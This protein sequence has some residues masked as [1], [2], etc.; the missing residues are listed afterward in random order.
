MHEKNTVDIHGKPLGRTQ[1]ILSQGNTL[2][3]RL[4]RWAPGTSSFPQ[5]SG[6]PVTAPLSQGTV[7]PPLL[8]LLNL[9]SPVLCDS[10]VPALH[11][12][13]TGSI[14]QGTGTLPSPILHILSCCS[15][16]THVKFSTL[17]GL[18]SCLPGQS[19]DQSGLFPA[20]ATGSPITHS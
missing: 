18:P 5:Q 13:N 16:G 2:E 19:S 4:R 17:A 7:P 15:W 9:S 1:G 20:K 8:M 3:S 10:S 12:P 14:L 11:V 6:H